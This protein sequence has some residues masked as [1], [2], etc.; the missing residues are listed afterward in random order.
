[1]P[2]SGRAEGDAVCP[3]L[4]S[5]NGSCISCEAP[6]D[7]ALSIKLV[8]RLRSESDLYFDLYCASFHHKLCQ[9]YKAVLHKYGE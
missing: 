8:F 2:H 9:I 6:E 7:T 1:M 5:Y 3:F 4:R